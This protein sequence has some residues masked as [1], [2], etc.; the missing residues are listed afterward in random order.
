MYP[1]RVTRSRLLPFLAA[2]AL[3]TSAACGGSGGPPT[4]P[5]PTPTP[6]PGPSVNACAAVGQGVN[7]QTAI[8]NGTVCSPAN[9]PVVLLQLIARDG[10][11]GGNCTGT[12]IA[13]RVILTAAHCLD[14]DVGSVNV[15]LGS[16]PFIPAESFT[17]H[18]RYSSQNTTALDVG[19]VKVAADLGRTPVPVLLSRDAVVG[20]AAI[21]A[22]WGRDLE[23]RTGDLR[24]G[25][26]TISG[27]DSSVLR[28][29]FSASA[30]GICQGDSGGPIMLSQGGVWSVAGVTSA[31]SIFTCNDGTNFYASVRNGE[32]R[33]FIEENAGSFAQR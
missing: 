11:P 12:I 4:N 5:T 17:Y 22:G 7:A 15:W 26:T 14:G 6:N 19:V 18:P 25:S 28:T 23:G 2:G 8:V 16:P 32:I 31:A 24:A 20:E 13:S 9:S 27:V 3:A 29:Q 21:V 10:H 1:E 33:R 30:A